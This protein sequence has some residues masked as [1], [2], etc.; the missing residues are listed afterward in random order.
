M[1]RFVLAS[2]AVLLLVAGAQAA[3]PLKGHPNLVAAHN[4]IKQAMEKI[5]AAQKAN[6]Y[7]MEGHA[8]KAKALL[9][10][11]EIEIKMAAEAANEHHR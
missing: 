8:A 4:E 11:A 6:E 3:G 7:D 1:K 9:E 2:S 10:Q 5:T